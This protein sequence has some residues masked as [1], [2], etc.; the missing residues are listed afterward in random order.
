MLTGLRLGGRNRFWDSGVIFF[1][2]KDRKYSRKQR[3]SS[4]KATT[5]QILGLFFGIISDIHQVLFWSAFPSHDVGLTLTV[6]KS[7]LFVCAGERVV[8]PESPSSVSRPS[9]QSV[10]GEVPASACRTSRPPRR[11]RV[12]LDSP[13]PSLLTPTESPRRISALLKFA[14]PHLIL[15]DTTRI[16]QEAGQTPNQDRENDAETPLVLRCVF[17]GGHRLWFHRAWANRSRLARK[18]RSASMSFSGRKWAFDRS[19]YSV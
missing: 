14:L 17:V 7:S 11:H 6:L 4:D 15:S 5:F 18:P 1:W 13:Q 19:L 8:R 10:A 16:Q 12:L 9:F 2:K 3:Q